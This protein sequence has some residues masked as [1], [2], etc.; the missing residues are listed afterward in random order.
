ML[1]FSKKYIVVIILSIIIFL[2]LYFC[3]IFLLKKEYNYKNGEIGI[4]QYND[5]IKVSELDSFFLDSL[6][7]NN[8]YL[9]FYDDA[10]IQINKNDFRKRVIGEVSVFA[11]YDTIENLVQFLKENGVEI[12][13]N[14]ILENRRIII[15]SNKKT[16]CILFFESENKVRLNFRTE[17]PYEISNMYTSD[18]EFENYYLKINEKTHSSIKEQLKYN[19]IKITIVIVCFNLICLIFLTLK[20][21]IIIKC[22]KNSV[23]KLNSTST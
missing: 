9:S 8:N 4:Y 10:I 5:K 2:T 23:T 19:F 15:Y 14:L 20:K 13:S 21:L 17:L 12:Q 11:K 1:N 18:D 16:V 7:V 6:I 22:K 3:W